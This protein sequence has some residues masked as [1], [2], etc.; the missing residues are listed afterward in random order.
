MGNACGL[1]G[2]YEKYVQNFGLETWREETTW[3]TRCRWKD[4]IIT[5]LRE[6][7]LESVDW[8]H[9]TQD[10]DHWWAL[11]YMVMNLQVPCK[12]GNFLIIWVAVSISRRTLL[13][14]VRQEDRREL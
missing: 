14:G 3:K 6:I 8:I 12:V 13:Y 5:D 1:Y 4:N 2:R 9:L 10:R 7:G 11:V